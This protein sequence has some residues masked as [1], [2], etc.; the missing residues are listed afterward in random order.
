MANI[1]V[2]DDDA[3]L[4]RLVHVHLK[5][6][7][8]EINEAACGREAIDIL[9]QKNTDLVILDSMMPQGDGA[10]VLRYVRSSPET[11]RVAIMMLTARN[12]AE[13]KVLAFGDG[14]DDYLVKPFDAGELVARVT[15]II[16]RNHALH[17]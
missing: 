12:K 13:D 15:R 3:L 9:G 2:V 4:R 10:S 11:S 14:A 7:G 6:R 1:L 5:A 8:H 16:S 17:A